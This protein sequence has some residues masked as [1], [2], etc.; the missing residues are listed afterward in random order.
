[1]GKRKK[2]RR[3]KRKYGKTKGTIPPPIVFSET[4]RGQE[5]AE[6]RRLR[7][8][9]A[10]KEP[11]ESKKPI[12]PETTGPVAVVDFEE[13][14]PTIYEPE[15]I[16]TE[17]QS[18]TSETI[19]TLEKELAT[20]EPLEYGVLELGIGE[21]TKYRRRRSTP[22]DEMSGLYDQIIDLIKKNKDGITTTEIMNYFEDLYGMP[23]SGKSDKKWKILDE[24]GRAE[25]HEEITFIDGNY[26]PC[27]K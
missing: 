11:I 25:K 22:I 5:A 3:I 23:T 9:V 6:R 8:A 16:E 18:M 20:D 15:N 12:E 26:F 14:V 10:P 21:I 7:Q 24:I 2:K 13:P 27:E 19:E 17:I 4:R 1:M